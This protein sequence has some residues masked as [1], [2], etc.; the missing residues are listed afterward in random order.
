[1]KAAMPAQ[2]VEVVEAC[3]KRFDPLMNEPVG[4][5]AAAGADE[6]R[7]VAC[8]HC[9]ANGVERVPPSGISSGETCIDARLA[10]LLMLQQQ[11]GHAGVGRDDE[12]PAIQV[13]PR[14]SCD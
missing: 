3:S 6:H 8:A 10:A 5:F 13:F 2:P 9:V 14:P 12:N 7:S 4:L 11:V 1:G